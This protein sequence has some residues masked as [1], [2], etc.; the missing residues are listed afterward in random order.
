MPRYT[1]RHD[2][3][4]HVIEL[5]RKVAERDLP[6]KCPLCKKP[7]ERSLATVAPP[8]V[9]ERVD[10]HR[11]VKQRQ[12]NAERVRK[13]AKKFFIE[14]EMPNLVGEHGLEQAKRAGWVKKDG[15]MVKV[16]DLK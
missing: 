9:L 1:Y 5:N 10:Q 7:M 6:A 16:G 8:T 11:N 14:N 15:K 2:D 4:D 12:N 13:R 3:P